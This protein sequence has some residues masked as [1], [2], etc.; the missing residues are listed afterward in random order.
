M[1]RM[2]KRIARPLWR[3]TSPVRR[4]IAARVEA[5]LRHCLVVTPPP[6]DAAEEV[7]LMMDYVVREIVRLQDDVDGL[8]LAV[9]AI[10][11]ERENYAIKRAS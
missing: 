4:P 1:K 3:A 6:S 8:R 7:V 2:V 10:A 9:E 11:A 5:F